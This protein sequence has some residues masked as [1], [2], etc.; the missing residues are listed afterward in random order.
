M[1]SLIAGIAR[2]SRVHASDEKVLTLVVADAWQRRG[3][4]AQLVRSAVAVSR[5][6]GTSRVIAK[7][8]P[9]N[10]PMRELLAENG[11]TFEKRDGLLLA[12]LAIA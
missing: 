4:G 6:E 1:G 2:L 7:L 3:I 8:S 9:D 11:F 10:V 5:K 12:S